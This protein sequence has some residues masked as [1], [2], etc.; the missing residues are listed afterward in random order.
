[1]VEVKVTQS[2][3][4]SLSFK[5]DKRTID[6]IKS[7]EG[8]KWDTLNKYWTVPNN[9][10]SINAIRGLFKKSEI[11]DQTSLVY[12]DN[13]VKDITSKQPLLKKVEDEL[14]IRGYSSKTIKSYKGQIRR[15]IEYHEKQ[16]YALDKQDI[17][18]YLLHL[19]SSKDISHSYVNQIVS[20]IKFLYK[21]VY[22][23]QNICID[24]ERPKKEK[25]LPEILSKNEISKL[26]KAVKNL[27][28]KAILYLVYSAGLRVGEVVK[29]KPTDI[30][31]DRMLIHIIQGKGKKDRY[32]ILSE[33]ALSILRQYVKVYK[34]EHWLF[35]GQH[36]DKHLTE[37]SV[38][39]VFDNARIDAK[40]RKD[41][42]VHNLRHSFAT[43][44]LEGG[45]NLRYIQELLGHSS[46]KTTEIYT[47]VTQK[48]LS[49]IISPLD[50]IMMNKEEG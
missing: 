45:V 21:N 49:N 23:M 27:K 47:H 35:P 7:I 30:D 44:L 32:T 38:Q 43:H 42:S 28:H 46:S 18:N 8:R 26:L 6:K 36:P 3:K 11:I 2:D 37:R 16:P 34:P 17:D 31:S 22:N 15:F 41:V 48:N 5:Y 40:I 19:L 20:A 14:K 50:T 25:K 13:K 24:L 10:N 4:L 39:K 33:T 29:L 12:N 9:I 1:M